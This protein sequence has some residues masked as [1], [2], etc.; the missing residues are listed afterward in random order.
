MLFK[1]NKPKK[2]PQESVGCF[3]L[4][5]LLADYFGCHG[6]YIQISSHQCPLVKDL[7]VGIGTQL[8]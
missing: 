5:Y 2:T 8:L 7:N 1:D 3:L 6:N 4:C